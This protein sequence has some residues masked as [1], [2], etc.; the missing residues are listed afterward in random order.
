MTFGAVVALCAAAYLGLLFAIAYWGDQRAA[1]RGISDS[2]VVYA[3]SIAVYCTSWTFYGSVGRAAQRGIDFLPIYFGPT[4]VFVLGWLVLRKMLRI[5]KANRITSIADLIASRFGKSAL[6]AGLVTV[7]AVVGTVPY[8][9]LQLKATSTTFS[10]M[11]AYPGPMPGRHPTLF[12]DTAFWVAALMAC[13]A[14]LFGTRH[15]DASERHHGMVVAI[16]FESLVKLMAFAAVGIFITFYL[17]DGFGDLFARAAR[18]PEFERLAGLTSA[19]QGIDWT[20]LMLL[21]MAAIFCLPRQFQVMIVENLSE[22]HLD[23][24]M[25]LFPLYLLAINLFVLPIAWAGRL[26]LGPGS[27]TDLFVL[28][29]PLHFDARWLA[30]VAFLGGLSAATGMVIVECV[31]VGTMVCNDLV[32]P[33]L[34]RFR[35]FAERSGVELVPILLFIRRATIVILLALGYLYMRVVGDSYALVSIGLV[36]FAAVAQFAPA[37]LF[38]LFWRRANHVGALLGIGGGTVVWLYTL[39]IPSFARSGLL[40]IELIDHGPLG[41]TWLKPYALFGLSQLDTITHSLFWSMLANI[42]GII[43]GSILFKQAPMERAQAVAFVDADREGATLRRASAPVAELE[44]LLGR[45]I[46]RDRAQRIFRA[47]AGRPDAVADPTLVQRAERVLAGAIGSSSARLVVGSIA[48]EE[49]LARDD[50]F[51]LL[52]ATSQA[53]EYSRRLE[54]ATTELTR[55]N[56]RLQELDR[57]KDEFLS[58]VSHELRTPLTSIRSFS[59]I[60]HDNPKIP[61]GQR[62]EFLG[63]VIRE[64]ERLTRLINDLLDLAKIESGNMQWRMAPV[65]PAS[66]VRAAADATGQLFRD[67][68]VAL[69]LDAPRALAVVSADADRMAQVMINLLSNAVKFCSAKAGRVGLELSETAT[70]VLLRV[71]DNGPGVAPSHREAIFDRFRQVGDPVTGKPAGTGLGLAICRT[72]VEQHGGSITVDG[73]PG[74]GARFTV[75]LPK[76]PAEAA[77]AQ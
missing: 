22:R 63:I 55:A 66:V 53:L 39:L 20:V 67:K 42:S 2:G 23:R 50:I 27:D 25:W 58:T 8:I 33:I 76:M 62:R 35:R 30:T 56:A 1:R 16:A 40:P 51:R 44:A 4:L 21:S 48:K 29:L 69:K 10:L 15:I 11:W 34:L 45:F 13:F 46:G 24:A 65:D 19:D 17:F 31:A 73:A 59:E 75:R 77:A 43:A 64:S 9:A 41:I 60:L 49:P 12:A 38:G 6:L 18:D 28:S 52:D 47:H 71:T 70:S 74:G 26:M 72:I 68:G 5:A 36:S 61:E 37:I 7:I 57:L 32:L 14:I 3:L 54:V